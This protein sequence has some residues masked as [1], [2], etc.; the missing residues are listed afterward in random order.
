M[1]NLELVNIKEQ[2]LKNGYCQFPVKLLDIEFYDVLNKNYLCNETKNLKDLIHNFRFDSEEFKIK[3]HDNEFNNLD[4]EKEKLY[5]E[6]KDT[7]GGISQLWFMNND[8]DK[9]PV[10][11][12]IESGLNKIVKFLYDLD[13]TTTITHPELQLTYYNKRCR[14]TP[15]VDGIAADGIIC[16]MLIYLNENYNKE[17]GGLLVFNDELIVPE[18]GVCALMDMTKHQIE[19]GVTEVTDGN[20]RFAILSFPKIQ[21]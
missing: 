14:F 8:A 16:S 19:H 20:G 9:L 6:Y 1:E 5:N 4:V 2:F 13:E 12:K 11:D 15:H 21:Q 18:F 3:H 10:K 7:V 17:H